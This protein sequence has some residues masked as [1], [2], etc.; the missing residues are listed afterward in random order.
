MAGFVAGK[1]LASLND[2]WKENDL[3][4]GNLPFSTIQN[5]SKEAL[6]TTL[7]WKLTD[8]IDES[9]ISLGIGILGMPGATAYGGLVDTLR[10][11]ISKGEVLFVSGA[12][13]AVGSMV[14]M[15]AKHVYGCRVIGSCGSEEKGRL[16]VDKFGFDRFINY[17]DHGTASELTAALKDAAP[18]GID[19]YF[20]NV[21]GIHFEAAMNCL[22]P[23]GR[24]AIC[25]QISEYNHAAPAPC[26][27]Y[28]L[29]MIYSSQ[30]IEGFVSTTWLR[31]PESAWLAAMHDWWKEGKVMPEETLFAGIEHWPEGFL[32]LFRGANTGKVVVLV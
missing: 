16:I 20:E 6:T 27:F 30:R 14:G 2:S 25:G 23:R 5:L 1:V 17:K 4:G 9:Q 3:F 26:V 19:M 24:V 18:E 13:G 22:R 10:P 32:S 21:G 12:A 11:S 15:I 31:D 8:L 7:L 29:R 28:P